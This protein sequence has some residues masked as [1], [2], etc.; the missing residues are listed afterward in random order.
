MQIEVHSFAPREQSP[1]NAVKVSFA[2]DKPEFK[3]SALVD[4]FI[5][6]TDS[7]AKMR[8][9]AIQAALEFLRA[10]VI[11]DAVET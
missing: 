9:K 2:E 5:D 10:V 11:E 6:P 1:K 4:V 8:E 3:S 7:L